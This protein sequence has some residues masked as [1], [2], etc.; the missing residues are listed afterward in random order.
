MLDSTN[1]PIE[2]FKVNTDRVRDIQSP[3]FSSQL[4]VLAIAWQ[5]D[6]AEC[7]FSVVNIRANGDL[8]MVIGTLEF[9][10]TDI[11]INPSQQLVILSSAR[12]KRTYLDVYSPDA[13]TLVRRITLTNDSYE[14]P[15]AG[16]Q[17]LEG[18]FVLL[19]EKGI[20]CIDTAATE[21]WNYTFKLPCNSSNILCDYN[22]NVII[23]ETQNIKIL[24]RN[25]KSVVDFT[26]DGLADVISMA[27]ATTR[28]LVTLSTEG[29]VTY[30]TLV[31]K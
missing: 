2:N 19:Y 6:S 1:H 9:P 20:K 4:G 12:D 15:V 11:F 10:P 13:Q 28:K 22:Y 21:I 29:R 14:N 3:S 26:L 7:E 30:W 16:V 31:S 25:G 18:S 24:D 27:F 5:N 23:K 8:K 17:N